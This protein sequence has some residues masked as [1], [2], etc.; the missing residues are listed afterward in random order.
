MRSECRRAQE[1]VSF[2][3][4]GELSTFERL[5]LDRHLA[6]CSS[7]RD[8]RSDVV[9]LTA[10]LR[11]ATPEPLERDVVVSRRPSRWPVRVAPVA[12]SLAVAAVGLGSILAS[13]SLPGSFEPS[14]PAQRNARYVDRTVNLKR[15]E[16]LQSSRARRA[17]AVGKPEVPAHGLVPPIRL[18]H[19]PF[20][21]PAHVE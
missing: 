15:L 17:S 14:R 19:T 8:F 10:A 9:A 4:D 5:L 6:Q 18:A 16:A 12:A 3:V 11:S 21:V 13:L 1:W 7:C 20:G 2:A